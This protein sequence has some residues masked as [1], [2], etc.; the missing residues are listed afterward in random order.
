MGFTDEFARAMTSKI[1]DR[2][3]EEMPFAAVVRDE[4][5]NVVS[6]LCK[7]FVT[8]DELVEYGTQLLYYEPRASE[9]T[10]EA[11]GQAPQVQ[12]LE[13]LR[14]K[15]LFGQNMLLPVHWMRMD[16]DDKRFWRDH[17]RRHGGKVPEYA[18]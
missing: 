1:A 3:S 10:C 4:G 8:A 14:D 13:Q 9:L 2:L 12:N 17:V 6:D 15:V 7:R 16:E 5:G 11:P 18:Y